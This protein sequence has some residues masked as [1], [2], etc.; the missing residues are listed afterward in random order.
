MIHKVYVAQDLTKVI[1]S[2]G[3]LGYSYLMVTVQALNRMDFRVRV[4]GL[5][6]G[7]GTLLVEQG[8]TMLG[9]L[10]TI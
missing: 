6:N 5:Y 10:R 8:Q 1:I 2:L 3:Y 4:A 7:V 9:L